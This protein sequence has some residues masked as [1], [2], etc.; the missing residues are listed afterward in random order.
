MGRGPRPTVVRQ[1][2]LEL[3]QRY[4]TPAEHHGTGNSATCLIH[5]VVA[6]RRLEKANKS[7]KTQQTHAVMNRFM[8]QC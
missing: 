5:A 6:K 3:L 7:T 1:N 4:V 8:S 2:S